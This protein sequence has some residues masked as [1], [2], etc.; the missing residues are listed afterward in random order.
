M[1]GSLVSE[2]TF[3]IEEY[4]EYRRINYWEQAEEIYEL[5][6]AR[7]SEIPKRKIQILKK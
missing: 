7:S 4:K 3:N 2:P 6:R 1:D 5:R